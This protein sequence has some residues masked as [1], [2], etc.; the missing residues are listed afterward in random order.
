MVFIVK[1]IV[2]KGKEERKKGRKKG[3]RKKRK[4][5]EGRKEGWIEMK[6][7]RKKETVK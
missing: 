2:S 3:E 4:R 6:E 1:N 7:G 5:K